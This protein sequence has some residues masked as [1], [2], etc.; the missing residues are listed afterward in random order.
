[1]K[2][3][4]LKERIEVYSINWKEIA[5]IIAVVLVLLGMIIYYILLSMEISVLKSDIRNLDGQINTLLVRVAEYNRLKREVEELE[6]IREKRAS[7][8]YVWAEAIIEQG[9][10]IPT[11]AM[12]TNLD[13]LDNNITIIGIAANNQ[14][15]LDLISNMKASPIYDNVNIISVTHH[16]YYTHFSIEAVIAEEKEGER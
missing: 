1:M 2:V 4:L 5:T 7:L 14:K 13:I 10:V 11:Q 16:S 3:N 8:K 6:D 9:Y 15:V 12:L